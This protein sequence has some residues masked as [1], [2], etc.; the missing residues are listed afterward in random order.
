VADIRVVWLGT[1]VMV[2]ADGVLDGFS[3]AQLHGAMEALLADSPTTVVLDLH[4]VQ[5]I[6]DGCIAVLAAAA[7][8]LGHHGG[9]V[10]LRLPGGRALKVASAAVLRAVLSDTYPMAGPVDEL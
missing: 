1:D 8:R 4:S 9:V 2:W 7:A 3:A 5:V 6:D 10:E